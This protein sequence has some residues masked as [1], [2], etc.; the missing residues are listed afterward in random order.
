MSP[1]SLRMPQALRLVLMTASIMIALFMVLT[2]ETTG[3]FLVLKRNSLS[4]RDATPCGGDLG[5]CPTPLVCCEESL[6]QAFCFSESRLSMDNPDPMELVAVVFDDG[7]HLE[8]SEKLLTAVKLAKNSI[9]VLTE[10]CRF[11]VHGR[12]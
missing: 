12:C 7:K 9:A 6:G 8:P 2:S 11:L 1:N 10:A 5:A 3:V 4:K